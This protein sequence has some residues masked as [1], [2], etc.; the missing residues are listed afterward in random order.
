MKVEIIDVKVKEMT[1]FDLYQ[2]KYWQIEIE[3]VMFQRTDLQF[4]TWFWLLWLARTIRKR[5]SHTTYD[6]RRRCE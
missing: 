4:V 2:L 5:Q 6:S 3:G 1:H